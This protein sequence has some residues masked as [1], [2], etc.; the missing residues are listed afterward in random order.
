M[1]IFT[2]LKAQKANKHGMFR[3]SRLKSTDVGRI[4]DLIVRDEEGTEISVD[5]GVAVKVGLNTGVGLQTR[6]ATVA[7]TTDQVAIVGSPANVKDA[8]TRSQGA[9]Y[10]FYHE[11]GVVAKAYE[12]RPNEG[13]IFGV[14]AYQ[15][16]TVL[17]E[18]PAFG[19][20][21]VVDG[22]GGYVELA[23][24]ADV[25]AYGFAGRVYGFEIGDNETI[26]LIEVVKNEQM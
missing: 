12:V 24:D 9:E 20:Q 18:V 22:N 3:S 21:V 6:Y 23:A 25:S 17:A 13:E 14:A 2:N 15:F 11:A 1:A 19:N 26:V 16:S 5:N 10:N 7:K 8:F 4:W